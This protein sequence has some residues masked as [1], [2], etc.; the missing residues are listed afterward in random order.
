MSVLLCFGMMNVG[1]VDWITFVIHM[2]MLLLLLAVVMYTFEAFASRALFVF[3]HSSL[4]LLLLQEIF[5]WVYTIIK[6][7][8]TPC[9][10]HKSWL[11]VIVIS[12]SFFL[13]LLVCV[14]LVWY[15]CFFHYTRVVM[16]VHKA[17]RKNH[18]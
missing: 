15:S 2:M 18:I 17:H 14:F 16:M 4:L 7:N 8:V 11:S 10:F 3:M 9:E 12:F 1:I 6:C 5:C 13:L